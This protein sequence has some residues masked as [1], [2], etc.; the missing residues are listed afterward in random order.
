MRILFATTPGIGHSFPTVPLA[1]ALRLAGHEVLYATG[2]D[3]LAVREAGLPVEDVCPGRTV[4]SMVQETF[5]AR[6]D[7]AAAYAEVDHS[8]FESTQRFYAVL[9]N[10]QTD[11]MDRYVAVA[12]EWQPDAVV[13]SSLGIGG[14]LA[15]GKV[16]VPA[17]EHGYG[18]VHTGRYTRDLRE[19]NAEC[20][21]RH[22]A[23][24]PEVLHT[25]DIAPPSVAGDGGAGGAA[26]PLRHLPYNGGGVVPEWLHTPSERPRVTVTLGTTA[27]GFGGL[28][29]LDRVIEL[30]A[31]TDAEFVLAL[32]DIDTSS[33]PTLPDNARLAGWVPLNL[34]LGRSAGLIHHG[35]SGT[36]LAALE[37]GLPQIL[38]PDQGE[39]AESAARVAARGAGLNV[40]HEEISAEHVDAL[41]NDGAL[42]KCAAEVRREIHGLPLPA[43]VAERLVAAVAG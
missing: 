22:D 24:L 41:L 2:G 39:R 29:P 5:A 26:W 37:A 40:R 21:E 27:P 20:F 11:M 32:G 8:S 17:F 31:G 6:P 3:A 7:L 43:A 13:F 35:G 38:M 14:L 15:A 42:R 10:Q 28:G 30:A 19:W 9:L 23:E 36:T 34:L 18:F 25:I 4:V 16:G 33:L 12:Q 1:W